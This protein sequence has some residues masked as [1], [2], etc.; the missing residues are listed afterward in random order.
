MR[1]RANSCRGRNRERSPDNRRFDIVVSV[2]FGTQI[3]AVEEI[4]KTNCCDVWN[5]LC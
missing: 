2:A 5:E 3:A 1:D 4:S